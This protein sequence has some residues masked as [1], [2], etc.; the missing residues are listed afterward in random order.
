MNRILYFLC[1][2]F[3]SIIFLYSQSPQNSEKDEFN[4]LIAGGL[5][6]KITEVN[7]QLMLLNGGHTRLIF[8]KT[9]V[10]GING[11]MAEVPNQNRETRF[12]CGGLLFEYIIGYD[13]LIHCSIASLCGLGGV[14]VNEYVS[15]QWNSA[16]WGFII[17]EPELYITLNLTEFIR[18][19]TGISYRFTIGFNNKPNLIKSVYG[20][21]GIIQLRIGGFN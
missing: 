19:C 6:Y 1:I 15:E 13:Y 7:K 11:Y 10:V 16:D 2:F 17:M 8:N 3:G 21:A 20:I 5:S 12:L 14:I 4:F 18:L 9:Y